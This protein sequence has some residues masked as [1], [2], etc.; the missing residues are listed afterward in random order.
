VSAVAFDATCL[1]TKCDSDPRL[2]YRLTQGFARVMLE[3][4]QSSRFRML[5]I[6]GAALSR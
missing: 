4:L 6:Y 1:R 5:D 2:G 3:R